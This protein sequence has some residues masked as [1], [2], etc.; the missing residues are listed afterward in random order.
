MDSYNTSSVL[1]YNIHACF[2]FKDYDKL[3]EKVT[4]VLKIIIGFG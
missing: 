3:C 4:E 2:K 1:L